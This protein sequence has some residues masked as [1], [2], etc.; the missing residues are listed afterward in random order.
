MRWYRKSTAYPSFIVEKK[1]KS[2]GEKNGNLEKLRKELEKLAVPSGLVEDTSSA[3]DFYIPSLVS[4][5][6]FN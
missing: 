1:E 4:M 5:G 2:G 3:L 6:K